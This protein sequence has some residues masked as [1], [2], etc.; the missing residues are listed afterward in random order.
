MRRWRDL[1]LQETRQGS[2]AVLASGKGDP[3]RCPEGRR[4]CLRGRGYDGAVQYWLHGVFIGGLWASGRLY[5]DGIEVTRG[6]CEHLERGT[7]P[8]LTAAMPVWARADGAYYK[9][10]SFAPGHRTRFRL[11]RP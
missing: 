9:A 1:P 4:R 10:S 5:P 2:N 11:D 6:W 3:D 7:A 8:A